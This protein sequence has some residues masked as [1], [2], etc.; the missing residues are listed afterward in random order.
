MKK[1]L[2][3]IYYKIFKPERK[4]QLVTGTQYFCPVC[5]TPVV[6]YLPLPSYYYKQ[7]QL[8]GFVYNIFQTE[9]L[10]LPGY[11]CDN[12]KS[13]DRDRLY[14]LYL[15]KYFEQNPS[16]TISLLDIAPAQALQNFIKKFPNVKYR[17]T[18]LFMSNVDDVQDVT[19]MKLYEDNRFDFLICSHVLEHIP[20]DVK[21][22]HELFRVLKPGGKGIIM[23]PINLGVTET[24]ENYT[25]TSEAYRWKYFG[26]GDHVR[27]YAKKDFL[28]RLCD[29]G[30]TIDQLGIDYFSKEVFEKA[31]I[32]NSSILYI[33]TK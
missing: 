6:K 29:C 7:W 28:S 2:R 26:Q 31:G 23:V 32:F 20:D 11:T 25:E 5:N 30:F 13:G 1:K 3:R 8:Y 21:A 17:S 14:A 15:K 33:V 18:D 27:M 16:S 19:D 12:C 22:M 9:T 4:A 10:N 24:H